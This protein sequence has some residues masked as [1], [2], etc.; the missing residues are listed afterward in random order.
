MKLTTIIALAF[1]ATCSVAASA[2]KS[3]TPVLKSTVDSLNYAFGLVNGD[4]IKRFYLSDDSTGERLKS[5]NDGI[6]EGK[7]VD[8][9]YA[10]LVG[11]ARNMGQ[12]LKEQSINGFL[13]NDALVTDIEMI[14]AG[15]INGFYGYEQMSADQAQQY[16]NTTLQMLNER[17]IEEQ[18][19]DNRRAGEEFLAENKDKEGVVTTESGL[20]YKIIVP[21]DGPIPQETDK[22]KVHYHGTLI[23][24]T[25]F[26]SSVESGKPATFGV[27]Q[28]IK[29][30][31]EALLLMPVGSKWELYIPY[32][33][34]YGS[35]DLGDIKPFSTLIFE[36]ELLGIE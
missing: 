18:Y 10:E 27:R 21:G 1:A 31:T 16:V 19:G 36:V 17:K 12:S 5:L 9:R 34:A 30:W 29:G 11:I 35:Q 20:Q 25:V 23:D 6:A 7:K 32:N 14:K 3:A 13:G 15:L 8:P 24:G 28:V 2:Q 22:V 33:L 26:D 4:G